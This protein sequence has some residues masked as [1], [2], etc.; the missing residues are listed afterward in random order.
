MQ[1]LWNVIQ[2]I[3]KVCWQWFI[4]L[5]NK[6]SSCHGRRKKTNKENLTSFPRYPP[7]PEWVKKEVIRLKILTPNDGHRKIAFAFNRLYADKHKMTV[8]RTFVGFTIRNHQYDIQVLRRK[9]KHK[10][11]KP[12][13][14]NL[15]W[16]MDLTGKNDVEKTQYSVLLNT[17]VVPV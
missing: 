17:T 10:Q 12:I 9:L 1:W 14:N 15:V 4:T 16:A 11:P 7:K 3:V 2:L 6:S 8:G 13:T 5:F